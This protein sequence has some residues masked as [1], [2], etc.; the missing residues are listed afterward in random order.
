MHVHDIDH[1]AFKDQ[2]QRTL[3]F[4]YLATKAFI[5]DMLQF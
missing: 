1:K 3:E 5:L 4:R 2:L